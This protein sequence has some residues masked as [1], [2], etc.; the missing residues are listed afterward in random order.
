MFTDGIIDQ[1]GGPEGK[2]FSKKRLKRLMVEINELS[3]P[4]QKERIEQELVNWQ[5]EEEL[6]DDN[7]LIGIEI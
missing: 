5:G 4:E 6:T 7:L 1:F 2:R 3:L